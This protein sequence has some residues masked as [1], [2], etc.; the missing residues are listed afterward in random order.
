MIVNGY[1]FIN[2]TPKDLIVRTGDGREFVF[3]ASGGLAKMDVAVTN[4]GWVGGIQVVRTEFTGPGDLPSSEGPGTPRVFIVSSLVAEHHPDNPHLICPDTGP[5]A[6][7]DG[8]R[9]VS[10]RRFQSFSN[11]TREE[12]QARFPERG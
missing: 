6:E 7:K 12:F 9:I 10:V 5:S 2:L 1:D 11:M 8:G 4:L 3:P